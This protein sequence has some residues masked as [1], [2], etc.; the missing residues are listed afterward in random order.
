[1][2]R[3]LLR[4]SSCSS[5]C[6]SAAFFLGGP[7]RGEPEPEGAAAFGAAAAGAGAAGTFGSLMTPRDE[8]T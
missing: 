8:V 5:G 2:M 7:S 3:S 6:A 1:M 4:R